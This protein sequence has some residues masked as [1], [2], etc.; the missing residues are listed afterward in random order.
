MV[1]LLVLREAQKLHNNKFSRSI[2]KVGS[3]FEIK[4]KKFTTIFES[5][6]LKSTFM[7]QEDDTMRLEWNN[8]YY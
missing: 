5:L 7:I 8:N 6:L 1:V 4:L 3:Y 2:R